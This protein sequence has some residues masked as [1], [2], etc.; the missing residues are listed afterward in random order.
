MPITRKPVS[1]ILDFIRASQT[2]INDGGSISAELELALV[3]E[4]MV[5]EYLVVPTDKTLRHRQQFFDD[6]KWTDLKG[7]LVWADGVE[8]A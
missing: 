2:T 6:M 3:E 8:A 4:M 1:D 5:Q 7:L